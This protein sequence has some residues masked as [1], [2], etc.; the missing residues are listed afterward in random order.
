MKKSILSV[1]S[2]LS[3][4]EQR[5]VNGGGRGC[6]TMQQCLNDC[7]WDCVEFRIATGILQYISCWVCQD[8]NNYQ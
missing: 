4:T 8:P 5:T 2:E 6:D 7:I 1:G 3:K